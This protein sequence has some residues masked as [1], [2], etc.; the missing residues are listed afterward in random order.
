MIAKTASCEHLLESRL[1]RN[2]CTFVGRGA[3]GIYVA[4]KAL[5][6]KKGKVILP[7]ICCPSPAAVTTIAGLTPLFCDVTLKDFGL[8]PDKLEK[9]LLQ[10]SDIV[11]IIAVHLYGI[12]CQIDLITQLSKKY[13]VPVIEDAAQ[14]MGASYKNKP[15]GSWGNVSVLS[16]GH[17]KTIDVGW[18]GA[19]LTDDEKLVKKI[20]AEVKTLPTCPSNIDELYELWRSVYYRLNDW[21]KVSKEFDKLFFPL[22]QIFKNMYLFKDDG[23]KLPQLKDALDQL[24]STIEVRRL[25]MEKYTDGLESL[26][27]IPRIPDISVPWRFSFLSGSHAKQQKIIKNLREQ[28]INVSSWYP[29]LDRWYENGQI[30]SQD[31]FAN[32]FVVESEI[33]NLWVNDAAE[34]DRT[35]EVL[36]SVEKQ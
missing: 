13:D 22:P 11:A 5:G 2:Y 17:S 14:A 4:L 26:F 18:G 9:L 6:L 1:G 3:S 25:N 20:R 30:N 34:V 23:H 29:C 16:F 21:R 12:P 24:D 32:S 28:S 19:V 15:L 8:C 35:I 10:H 36:K 33:I 31:D 27:K 7:N